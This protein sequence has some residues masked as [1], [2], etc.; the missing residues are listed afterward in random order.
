MLK[1]A[2]RCRVCI[3]WLLFEGMHQD[4]C[5]LTRNCQTYPG[6]FP[7]GPG[8][9]WIWKHGLL[10]STPYYGWKWASKSTSILSEVSLHST[11]FYSFSYSSVCWYACKTSFE[12]T[13]VCF[14][15]LCFYLFEFIFNT[16]SK[17]EP[18]AHME[19]KSL[20]I[21]PWCYLFY[22]WLHLFWFYHLT[23][24]LIYFSYILLLCFLC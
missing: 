3:S 15:L 21:S 14:V 18:Q 16:S 11:L 6:E 20:C 24:I 23:C 7:T 17:N 2:V 8:E 12:N 5:V 4:D 1:D 13:F 19:L 10:V 9:C 22:E